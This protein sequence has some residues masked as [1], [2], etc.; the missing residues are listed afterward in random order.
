MQDFLW[1]PALPLI[2]Q[3]TKY[4]FNLDLVFSGL[5]HLGQFLAS[6]EF[7]IKDSHL[8]SMIG[9][10]IRD[11][12]SFGRG[13]IRCTV[14]KF[15][16]VYLPTMCNLSIDYLTILALL[17]TKYLCPSISFTSLWAC[18][19]RTFVREVCVFRLPRPFNLLLSLLFR[20]FHVRQWMARSKIKNGSLRTFHA[21]CCL[22]S[23][24][25]GGYF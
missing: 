21:L 8:I 10:E 22:V 6:G 25:E 18:I 23:S 19:G 4:I 15:V 13:C 17:V 5:S 3:K 11:S 7:P 12:R 1:A 2:F 16:L 24:C 9:G 20:H 14:A